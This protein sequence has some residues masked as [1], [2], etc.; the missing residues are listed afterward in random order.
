MIAIA[1]ILALIF[2][3]LGS[4]HFYWAFFGISNP[5]K[6]YPSRENGAQMEYTPGKFAS[7]V[8]GVVLL[9]FA[10][11]FLNRILQFFVFPW[12]YYVLLGIGT[13]FFLRGMGD[14]KYLG[15]FK[16]VRGT[17]F[18]KMDTQYYTP[19]CFCIAGMV[20]ALQLLY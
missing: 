3:F 7:S 19:L 6:V 12:E 13:L 4:V 17:P 20:F 15:L 1:S 9:L 16:K 11:L 14:F 2:F 18:A 5:E 8:V 10:L